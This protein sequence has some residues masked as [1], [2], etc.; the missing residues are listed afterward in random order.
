MTSQNILDPSALIALIP[1]LL[2]PANRSIQTPQDALAVLS[3]AILTSLGFRLI[4][5]DETSIT[6]DNASKNVLPDAWN[7][8]GPG[9]YTFKYRHEQSSLEFVVK[10]GKLGRRTVVN[11]IA[12]ESDKTTTLDISTDD[13]T[14]PA[15]FPYT[16][17]PSD[18]DHTQ[19]PLVHVYISSFRITD[20]VSQ[21]KLK[22]IQKL[23]PGLR[24]DGYQEEV[25]VEDK[26]ATATNRNPSTSTANPPRT[27]PRYDPSNDEFPM[28][29][30][31]RSPSS[32]I[33]S[34]NPLEI[35]RRDL[36]PI[37]AGSFQPPPLFPPSNSGDGM[38]V[39]PDH[40]IFGGRRSGQGGLLGPFGPGGIGQ[41][42]PRG[43]WGGDGFLPPM[44]APPGARFDTVGPFGGNPFPGGGGIGGG[45]RRRLPGEGDP[46]NDEFMPPGAVSPL[47]RSWSFPV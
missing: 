36:D 17:S 39:G 23:V 34:N 33:P 28:R 18:S 45:N 1:T 20:F 4:G 31:P 8:H 32:H 24:K 25:D 3:H 21:F 6:N 40:P 44:G 38:F 12:V 10:L 5:V 26:S 16:F 43:P 19:T 14:S 47:F 42:S 35:G 41:G 9:G 37:P 29:L 15:S 13:F 30:P 11:A 22:I 46:D 7:A 2:P 27:I